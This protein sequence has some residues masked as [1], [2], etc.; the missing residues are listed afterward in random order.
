MILATPKHIEPIR[1]ICLSVHSPVLGN[2]SIGV[3]STA[4]VHSLIESYRQSMGLYDMDLTFTF[5]GW[6]ISLDDSC[7]LVQVRTAEYS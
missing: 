4:S 5:R 2:S 3:E 6:N 1:D 7:S